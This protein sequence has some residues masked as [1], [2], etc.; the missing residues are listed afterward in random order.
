[1]RRRAVGCLVLVAIASAARAADAPPPVA[2]AELRSAVGK[3]LPPVQHSQ[4][5]W[6]KKQDCASCHHQLVPIV[7]F[8][9]SLDRGLAFNTKAA[10]AVSA[11]TFTPLKDID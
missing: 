6:D 10:H 11:K 5:V 2:E 9:L 8:R 1:M 4:E 3:A 7:T